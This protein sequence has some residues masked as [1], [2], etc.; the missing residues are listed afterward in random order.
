MLV[1]TT[2]DWLAAPTA[3]QRAERSADEMVASTVVL[4]AVSTVD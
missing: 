1:A 3:D 2:V 4:L